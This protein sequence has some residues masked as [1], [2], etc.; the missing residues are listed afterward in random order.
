MDDSVFKLIEVTGTS[1][2][3]LETAIQGA[4]ARAGKTVRHMRWFEVTEIRGSVSE[5]QVA[6]FQVTLKIGFNLDN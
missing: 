4:L 6:Q 1:T 3:G 2:T 5:D